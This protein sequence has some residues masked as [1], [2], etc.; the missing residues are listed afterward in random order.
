MFTPTLYDVRGR[1]TA[2][3]GVAPVTMSSSMSVV[4]MACALGWPTDLKSGDCS[5]LTDSFM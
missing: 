5:D 4:V 1:C 3:K 2:V